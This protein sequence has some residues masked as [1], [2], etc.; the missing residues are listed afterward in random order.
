MVGDILKAG[1]VVRYNATGSRWFI[2]VVRGF[3][4]TDVE[5][6]YLGG[7]RETVPMKKVED[8]LTHL[9]RRQRVLSLTRDNLCYAFYGEALFRLRQERADQMQHF[10]RSHGLRYRPEE[11]SANA[12]IQIWPDDSRVAPGPTAADRAFEALLPKWL[13]P[14]RLPPGSRDPLGFQN[15]AERLANEF[16]PGL[17]V[18]TT[19]IEYYGLIA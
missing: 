6:Q 15:S 5:I 10:L 7:E 14:H 3:G 8:L 18:F 19:R 1:S 13:E 17:T 4:A 16:L 2:A 12:R 9:H 11:W